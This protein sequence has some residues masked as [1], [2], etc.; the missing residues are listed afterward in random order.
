MLGDEDSDWRPDQFGY[1]LWGCEIGFKFPIVKLL[2]Y[3][4]R[5]A[6]LE[7]S[8]NP[9]A[10]VMMA[11]LK[12]QETRKEMTNR[13]EWKL[14]LVKGLYEQGF[15]REDILELFRFIDWLLALPD[16]LARND[17]L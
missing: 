15:R 14:S 10:K 9:F 6:F 3:K 2:D 4:E 17:S 11:H 16:A 1:H 12:A 7:A 5:W 8:R 13:L